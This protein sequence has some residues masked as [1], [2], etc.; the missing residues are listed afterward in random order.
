MN[1]EWIDLL[2]PV[3]FVLAIYGI[4]KYH[5]K[6]QAQ[7]AKRLQFES[8]I[9]ATTSVGFN[10]IMSFVRDAFSDH[11]DWLALIDDI[12]WYTVVE[13]HIE[14][15]RIYG[16]AFTNG[17]RIFLDRGLIDEGV[18]VNS[19]GLVIHEFA[20]VLMGHVRGGEEE[21]REAGLFTRNWL[22]KLGLL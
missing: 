19:V 5:K 17:R 18:T 6:R 15:R 10:Q 13:P 20:H 2:I 7:K 8:A 3:L 21:E 14:G 11:I 9:P 12:D 16:V 1:I 22:N 4:M